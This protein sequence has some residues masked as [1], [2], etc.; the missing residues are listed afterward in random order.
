M[1]EQIPLVD[2]KAQYRAIQPEIDSA[3]QS[4]IDETR[5]IMGAPVEGFCESF[6]HFCG[7]KHA[8]AASSGT[9]ALH[10]ALLACG[11]QARDEV[12]V[13]S[14]TFIAT[15][16]AVCHC[17]AIPVFVDVDPGTYTID[18]EGI[19]AAI[20]DRTKAI[21]V[22]HLYGQCCDMDPILAIASRHGLK[23]VEDCAQSHGARYNGRAVGTIGDFG[24]FSF[25]PGKNLG[26]YGDAGM[27]TTNDGDAALRLRMLTNHGRTGKYEHDFIGYNYRMDALQAAILSAKLPHLAAWTESRKEIAQRY[28]EL[29]DDLPVETPLAEFDHVYHL[30]VIQL[31]DRDGLARRHIDDGLTQ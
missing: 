28:G 22:V 2:L 26:A 25:F 19:E 15:A 30:Y 21:V 31:D 7:A 11:V 5:F 9:T 10:L 8:I 23:V 20:T 27:I 18:P 17:S 3:I 14:H 6:A 24:A 29:L 12:I 13:P 4:T 16:E 1:S